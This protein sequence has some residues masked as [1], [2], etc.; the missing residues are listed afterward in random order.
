MSGV[1]PLSRRQTLMRLLALAMLGGGAAYCYYYVYTTGGYGSAAIWDAFFYLSYAVFG[2]VAVGM[3]CMLLLSIFGAWGNR[4][5]IRLKK[6]NLFGFALGSACGAVASLGVAAL[7]SLT[8]LAVL[9]AQKVILWTVIPVQA[10]IFVMISLTFM[11]GVSLAFN[12]SRLNVVNSAVERAEENKA[13]Q[14]RA[15]ESAQNGGTNAANSTV[16]PVAQATVLQRNNDRDE[17]MPNSGVGAPTLGAG[18]QAASAAY[19]YRPGEAVNSPAYPSINAP[20]SGHVWGAHA[21]QTPALRTQGPPTLSEEDDM[22]KKMEEMGFTDRLQNRV[23]LVRANYDINAAIE[24]IRQ[25][26]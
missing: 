7:V 2:C 11:K 13:T 18:R 4:G 10:I 16:Y 3:L 21:T 14:G 25:T 17:I 19:A 6:I 8:L 22:L 12:L 24:V 9:E 15:Y 23:A 1:R 5:F 20:S 26:S